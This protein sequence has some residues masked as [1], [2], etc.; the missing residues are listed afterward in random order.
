MS[1]KEKREVKTLNLRVNPAVYFRLKLHCVKNEV[2]MQDFVEA[3][4]ETELNKWAE[5]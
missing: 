2:S 3:L 5:D 1:Q 4:I